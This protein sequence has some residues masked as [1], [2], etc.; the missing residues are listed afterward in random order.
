MFPLLP[1][2]GHPKLILELQ[3]PAFL[4]DINFFKEFLQIPGG[5]I[6]WLSAL[7]CNFG[8]PFIHSHFF[9][10]LLLVYCIPH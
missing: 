3:S 10:T 2:S 1:F 6:D 7:S 9:N 8:R 5:L 4:M